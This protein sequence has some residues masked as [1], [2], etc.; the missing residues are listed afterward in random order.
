MQEKNI[1]SNQYWQDNARFADIM[2]VGMFQARKVL[3]ADRLSE[4]DGS[5][6]Y[7][8]KKKGQKGMQRYRDVTKKA[9]FGTHFMIMGI[10]NQ[11]DIHLAMPVRVMGNDFMH[12]DRQL[13]ERKAEH[14]RKKDLTK[15]EYLSGLAKDEKLYPVCTLVIYYGKEE[16]T[17]PRKLSEMLDFGELPEEVRN[18]VADYPIHVIDARRFAD[19]EKLETEARLL[20]GMMQRDDNAEEC[21]AYLKENQTEFQNISEDTFEA[22]ATFTGTMKLLEQKEKYENEEGEMDMCKA[23]D[24]M[25]LNGEKRGREIGEKYGK[26]LGEKKMLNLIRQMTEDGELE[27]IPRLVSEPKFYEE[28][29]V[30]YH[31]S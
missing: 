17:G 8:N 11:S 6:T 22:I 21:A 26:E 12:Y 29:L 24:D 3:S 4:R 14:D 18:V 30:K 23:I 10:E 5:L 27:S 7:M 1:I 20:F 16:W 28:M 9:D 25:I 19:S 2:N 13:K 15:D 31:V